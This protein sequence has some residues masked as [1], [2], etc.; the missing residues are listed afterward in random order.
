MSCAAHGLAASRKFLTT[1]DVDFI[2][3]L[4][5]GLPPEAQVIDLG[6]GSG[7]TALALFAG[8]P[9]LRVTTID[10][11]E[12]AL[13]WAAL[14]VANA[15]FSGRHF[16]LNLDSLLAAHLWPGGPLPMVLL[17]TSHEEQATR[18]EIT[19]WLPNLATGGVL[20]CHDYVGTDVGKVVDEA[21]SAGLFET[22]DQRGL[23]WAGRKL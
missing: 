1:E 13:N 4:A 10:H 15:G 19:N 5:R 6:A 23:G 8:N 12:E 14:A 20:W 9:R 16:I 2:I 21:V 17:D 3:E 22:I 11:D 7:T 18:D